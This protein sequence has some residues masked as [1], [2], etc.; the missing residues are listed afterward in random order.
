MDEIENTEGED[1]AEA[2]EETVPSNEPTPV[3]EKEEVATAELPEEKE[4][5][6]EEEEEKKDEPE[7]V[8]EVDAE[9]EAEVPT[10]SSE[11]KVERY[12]S[13]FTRDSHPDFTPGDTIRVHYKIIE[14]N[15][16]RIQVF[17]GVVI[18]IK[19]GGLD[20]TFTV[21][22]VSWNVGVER[23][24]FYNSRKIDKIVI[25]RRGKV[26]RAKIYYLRDRVGKAARIKELRKPKPS[27]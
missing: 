3:G 1:L 4:G 14:G 10:L 23:T 18:A 22:K 12:V 21:R 6:D 8:E 15:K 27:S 25:V 16:E 11:E 26:R 7:A 5:E 17:E 2:E 19:H 20:K 24:F 9:V 13:R